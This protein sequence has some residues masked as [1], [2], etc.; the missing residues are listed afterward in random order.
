LS[1]ALFSSTHAISN[2]PPKKKSGSTPG[3]S[4]GSET[5]VRFMKAHAKGWI[6]GAVWGVAEL[7]R[8]H[9]AETEA[10]DMLQAVAN[11]KEILAHA[12]PID[13]DV[14]REHPFVWRVLADPSS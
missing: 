7:L 11:A 9:G 12:D 5:L 3:K 8:T 2:A 14:I 1:N 4:L 10:K 13:L 6:A